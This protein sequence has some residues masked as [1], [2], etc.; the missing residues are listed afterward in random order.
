M[1]SITEQYLLNTYDNFSR[2]TQKLLND[3]KNEKDDDVVKKLHKELN[4]L[5]NIELNLLKLKSVKSNIKP[6]KK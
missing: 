2:E 6:L 1:N 5:H 3:V 4:L